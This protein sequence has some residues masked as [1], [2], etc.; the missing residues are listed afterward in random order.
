MIKKIFI[1]ITA[2]LAYTLCFSTIYADTRTD[3]L[4]IRG[5]ALVESAIKTSEQNTAKYLE[6][7]EFEKLK[8]K[9]SQDII[10]ETRVKHEENLVKIREQEEI[11]KKL[12]EKPKEIHYTVIRG[13]CL[14]RIA[15]KNEV[16]GDPYKWTQVYYYNQDQIKNPD[17]IYPGQIFRIPLGHVDESDM[18]NR[19][20]VVK[21]DSLWKIA[22]YQKIYGD[23]YKWPVIYKAN[24]KFIKD[25]S[26]IY[27]YQILNIPRQ[28]SKAN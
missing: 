15:K 17:L 25:P 14:W 18:P 19:Y 23:P 7:I 22:G 2:I 16:Y 27:P 6:E 28:L 5:R 10:S 3:E 13:D 24:K 20:E 1:I 21:G 12:E 4:L 8:I 26:I 9:E 11:I